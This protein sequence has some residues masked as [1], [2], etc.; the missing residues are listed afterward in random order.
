MRRVDQ[1]E[2]LSHLQF[3]AVKIAGTI[4]HR[5]AVHIRHFDDEDITLPMPIVPTQSR[6]EGTTLVILH[7]NQPAPRRE[8]INHHNIAVALRN[9][10]WK[11]VISVA[12]N[13]EHVALRLV[14]RSGPLAAV[15]VALFESFGFIRN[16]AAIA[17]DAL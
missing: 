16:Y 7:V 3:V 1:P 9:L 17:D 11:V 10:E 12:R 8:R 13:T 15:F 4:Q 2:P 6:I 14:V 5:I